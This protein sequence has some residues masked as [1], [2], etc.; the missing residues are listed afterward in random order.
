M[1]HR[2]DSGPT[3]YGTDRAGSWQ[4]SN[5]ESWQPG[6]S[7]SMKI[8]PR[9]VVGYESQRPATYTAPTSVGSYFT[10]PGC[11]SMLARSIAIFKLYSSLSR[12]L[13]LFCSPT[14]AH[15]DSVHSHADF[16]YAH[17]HSL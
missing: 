2:G 17:W 12:V 7:Y 4:M 13:L 15:L 16:V 3:Q 5:R 9:T 10:P 8:G 6:A 1:K 14:L 11:L